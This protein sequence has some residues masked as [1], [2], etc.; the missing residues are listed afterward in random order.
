MKDMLLQREL[1]MEVQMAELNNQMHTLS[2]ASRMAAP[3]DKQPKAAEPIAST[4]KTVPML[5]PN[6]LITLKTSPKS[7]PKVSKPPPTGKKTNKVHVCAPNPLS[8]VSLPPAPTI[9]RT[10]NRAVDPMTTTSSTVGN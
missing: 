9:T 8:S 3:A 4:S 5:T 6:Q 2:A 7:E 10:Q 1:R